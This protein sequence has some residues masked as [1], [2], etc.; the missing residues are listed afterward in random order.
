[1]KVNE[2]TVEEMNA[3][4]EAS[5]FP[6]NANQHSN[7]VA[8]GTLNR[9]WEKHEWN[10]RIKPFITHPVSFVEGPLIDAGF[11]HGFYLNSPN[12]KLRM[13]VKLKMP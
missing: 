5:D 4:I 9:D 12:V 1:M 7:S 11:T 3:L 13:S 2:I 10:D 8:I 6:L